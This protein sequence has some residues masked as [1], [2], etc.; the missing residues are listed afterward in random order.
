[1]S[2]ILLGSLLVSTPVRVLII[3]QVALF[4]P[5]SAVPL[6]QSF[7]FAVPRTV[8]SSKVSY[9]KQK[10]RFPFSRR[11]SIVIY[12]SIC[13]WVFNRSTCICHKF[14]NLNIVHTRVF[15]TLC[16]RNFFPNVI[17]N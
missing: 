4:V 13:Y 17:S 15:L 16:V 6:I 7:L 2:F 14:L 12:L 8:Y 1:M 3:V 9:D 11:D 10:P 5:E